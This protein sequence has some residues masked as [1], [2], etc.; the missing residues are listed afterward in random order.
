MPLVLQTAWSARNEKS[1]KGAYTLRHLSQSSHVAPCLVTSA[2]SAQ[3]SLAAAGLLRSGGCLQL[4]LRCREAPFS[5]QLMLKHMCFSVLKL[6]A[7]HL[8]SL[9]EPVALSRLLGN[10]KLIGQQDQLG[11]QGCVTYIPMSFCTKWPPDNRRQHA[12]GFAH[13][14]TDRLFELLTISFVCPLTY[15]CICN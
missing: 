2:W 9:T 5:Q 15:S 11:C 8:L 13:S 10:V 3:L 4:K 12:R 7:V 6:P 1:A 14:V